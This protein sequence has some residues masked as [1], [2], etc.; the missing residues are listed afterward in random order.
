MGGGA[1]LGLLGGGTGSL[2]GG[3]SLRF[4][5][6]SV[7]CVNPFTLSSSATAKNEFSSSC[8]TFTSPWYMKLRT[9]WRSVNL[10]PFRY[11]RGWAWGL[12]LS[13]PLKKGEQAERMTLC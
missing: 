1:G 2:G 7:L 5:A 3:T 13:T 11:R 8:A 12:R 6:S 4:P 9:D 10:T